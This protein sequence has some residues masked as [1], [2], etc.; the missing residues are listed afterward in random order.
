[1][2]FG[3]K[4]TF[5]LSKVAKERGILTMQRLYRYLGIGSVLVLMFSLTVWGAAEKTSPS[6]SQDKPLTGIELTVYNEQLALVKDQRYLELLSGVSTLSFSEVSALLDPSSVMIRT[7]GLKG[8]RVLEQNFEHDIVNDAK[9]LQKYLGQKI[10]ITDLQGQII[11][12]YLLG[13]GD[14]LI[15]ASEPNGGE[16]R[17]VKS[18]QIKSIDFTKLP[19]GLMV[20]P[21]LVWELQNSNSTAKHLVEVSYLTGGLSWKADYI[22]TVS[23]DDDRIDLMGWV[24]L[25]NYSGIDY[26]GARLK[27]VAGDINRA[28]EE[29][30]ANAVQYLKAEMARN[31]DQS[32]QEQNFFEYHLYTL[33][34][35][36]TLKNNQLKQVELLTVA[37]VPVQK[38][39]IY[40]GLADGKRVKV[41]LEFENNQTNN[42]G[43]PLPKGTIRVQKA[44]HEG[45]LQLI[46]E[47]RIDHTPKDE[48]VRVYLGNAFDIVGERVRTQVKEPSK[49]LREET[50]KITLRNHKQESVSITAIE[51]V[52]G[53]HES[54]IIASNHPYR[55][56][57]AGKVEFTVTVPAGGE[58]VIE[59]TVRYKL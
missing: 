34:R 46:G 40:E 27:L 42:L 57:E 13:T 21:T 43:L 24:T 2:F 32:F 38:Q 49:N 16:V 22:A 7:P 8:V 1:M 44:D 3:T 54:K 55:K 36:T 25:T 48:K 33:T 47:D 4:V 37:N 51:N 52:S 50:Y 26:P 6:Q 17:I 9:L 59:Y 15:I 39:Y 28:P 19:G 18:T 11:E 41:M 30:R 29:D 35:P 10:R 23:Q 12:G 53:W 56:G 45:S 14:N 5:G 58:Q 31:A 20:R